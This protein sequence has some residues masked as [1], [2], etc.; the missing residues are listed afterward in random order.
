MGALKNL[1]KGNC[2]IYLGGGNS[3]ICNVHPN[4]GKISNLTNIF[5]DG[6]KPQTSNDSND[7]NVMKRVPLPLNVLLNG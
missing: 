1:V 7:S 2:P 6:L 5:S 3:N 4:L